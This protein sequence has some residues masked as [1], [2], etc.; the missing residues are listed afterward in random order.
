MV[1]WVAPLVHVADSC[2]SSFEKLLH[3]ICFVCVCRGGSRGFYAYNMRMRNI[4]PAFWGWGP[5]HD[6]AAATHV[7]IPSRLGRVR[8]DY[9]SRLLLSLLPF[10][11]PEYRSRRVLIFYERGGCNPLNPPPGSAPSQK[12]STMN[13]FAYASVISF[14][15][16]KWS[17]QGFLRVMEF[18]CAQRER[19]HAALGLQPR[20]C[21]LS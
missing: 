14:R 12:G 6:C 19:S 10:V 21:R 3:Q 4:V 20:N 13:K 15:N 16:V 7:R 17:R 1:G 8:T 18:R 2:V 9:R 11:A 5:E